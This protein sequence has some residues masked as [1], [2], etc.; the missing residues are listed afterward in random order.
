MLT[1]CTAEDT[2]IQAGD[3]AIDVGRQQTIAA[4]GISGSTNLDPSTGTQLHRLTQGKRSAAPE[5]PSGFG[6]A[7]P[8]STSPGRFQKSLKGFTRTDSG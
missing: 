3:S 7:R 2:S 4:K 1:M 5:E 6:L 8:G